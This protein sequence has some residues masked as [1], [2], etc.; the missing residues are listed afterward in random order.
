ME[1]AQRLG[2]SRWTQYRRNDGD[3][4]QF[5]EF[6]VNRRVKVVWQRDVDALLSF[7]NVTSVVEPGPQHDEGH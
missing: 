7:D 1:A 6:P 3:A 5:L 2:D 4:L